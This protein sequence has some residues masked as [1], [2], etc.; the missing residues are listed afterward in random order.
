MIDLTPAFAAIPSPPFQTLELGPLSF[1]MYGLCIALGALAGIAVAR[2]RWADWGGDP[3]DLTTIA[4]GAIPAGLVGARLYHV[5]TDFSDKYSCG[6]DSS[7]CWWPD[8]FLVWKGGLGIP[9]AV[10]LGTVVGIAIAIRI[11]LDWKRGLD[12]AAPALPIAQAI[13]RL[14]NWFNQEL[15]G[16]PTDLPWALEIGPDNRPVELLDQ[17]TFHP[18]FLYEGLWNLALAGLIIVGSNRIVLRPSRWFAVYVIGYGVGRLWVESLRIDAAT[19]LAGLRVNTW[20]S[21]VII[22]LGLL[23]LFW[24][25]SP[26]DAEATARHRAGEPLRDIFL[27]GPAGG[28]HPDAMPPVPADLPD[29]RDEILGAD[30]DPVDPGDAERSDQPDAA[31]AADDAD[32]ADDRSAQPDHTASD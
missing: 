5:V 7:G 9:G 31:D 27:L 3:E 28:L 10:L 1:R 2:K 30:P 11:G 4:L 29:V 18:T 14:G 13:G 17:P 12:V 20:M 24:R 16:R 15:Y 6:P 19:E 23:W 21:L 32:D 26:V 25:G 22:A 8:A